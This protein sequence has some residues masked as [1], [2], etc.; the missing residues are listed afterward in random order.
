MTR[1][2]NNANDVLETLADLI[3]INS[4]NPE[5]GGPGE[6]E[7]AEYV[8]RFFQQ[9][10]VTTWTEE[11]LPGRFNVYAKLPGKNANQRVVLEAHMDTVSTLGMSMPPFEP[12]R[13]GNRIYGRGACDVKAGLAAMMHA[14]R[15]MQMSG[16]QPPAEV[17]LAAVIDEEHRYRGVLALLEQ[18]PAGES[19]Q[20]TVTIVAEPT[21]CRIAIAN[22]GVL[23]WQVVTHGVAA[24]SSKPHTGR[25]AIIEMMKVVE[26]LQDDADQLT[27]MTHPLVGSPTLCISMIEGGRQI[28]FVPDRCTLSLDRRLLPGESP[29]AVLEHYRQMVAAL[30]EV[31]VEFELPLISDEAFDTDINAPVVQTAIQVA[32]IVGSESRPAGVPFGCDIT[33]L[34]RAGIPGIIFG[35]GSIDQAHGAFEYVDID[36]VI[37]AQQFYQNFLFEYGR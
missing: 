36:Q 30:P 16:E 5:W 12:V 10:D 35:P 24:H 23:R 9:C 28:N 19:E 25:N 8:S 34:S 14:M 33:K 31:H 3:S 37:M 32:G 27:E 26:L 20:Q 7:V 21:D 15:E 4:V 22:K 17:W 1:D 2:H 11:V 6:R 13:N 29:Q 18:L